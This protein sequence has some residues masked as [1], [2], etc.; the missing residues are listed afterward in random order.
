[1]L[2]LFPS[3]KIKHWDPGWFDFLIDRQTWQPWLPCEE[4]YHTSSQWACSYTSPA[5]RTFQQSLRTIHCICSCCCQSTILSPENNLPVTTISNS[6]PWWISL[7]WDASVN[8]RQ[9]CVHFP[10]WP[11]LEFF[12][13]VPTEGLCCDWYKYNLLFIWM[14]TTISTDTL[15]TGLV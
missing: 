15:A 5:T 1:M 6:L 2:I 4:D 13:C 9:P 3:N 7:S 8:F 14:T 10:L 11:E 12:P